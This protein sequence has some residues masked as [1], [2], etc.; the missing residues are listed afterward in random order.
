[1]PSEP[2][3]WRNVVGILT[4]DGMPVEVANNASFQGQAIEALISRDAGFLKDISATRVIDLWLNTVFAHGGIA[5]RNKRGDFEA[6][7]EK[8][9]QGRFEYAFRTLVK[10]T[11]ESFRFLSTNAAQPALTL[12]NNQLHLQPSFRLDAAFGTKRKE[13]TRDGDTIVRQA[14]SEHFTEE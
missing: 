3:Y 2:S 4:R 10:W 9:G 5:G 14:S 6:V 1:M 11:G 7:A 13:V 8:H 12:F